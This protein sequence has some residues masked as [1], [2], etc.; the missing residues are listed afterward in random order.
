M[1]RVLAAEAAGAMPSVAVPADSTERAHAPTA[2]AVHRV[3]DRAAVAVAEE[4]AV[5][6]GRTE[7]GAMR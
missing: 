7:K 6:A 1:S 5:G 2:A 4:V 3:W